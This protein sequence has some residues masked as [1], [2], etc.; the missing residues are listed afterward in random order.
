L[1]NQARI[2]SPGKQAKKPK[3]IPC[4]RN[5]ISARAEKQEKRWLLLRFQWKKSDKMENLPN[6]KAHM[7]YENIKT[8]LNSMRLSGKHKSAS[9]WIYFLP[10]QMHLSS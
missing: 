6:F 1:K 2:F 8:R 3:K 5:G 9:F 10:M 7:E 4:N